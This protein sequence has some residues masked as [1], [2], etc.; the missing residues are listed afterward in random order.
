MLLPEESL[1]A[2][3]PDE[4]GEAESGPKNPPRPRAEVTERLSEKQND[5][6]VI[7]KIPGPGSKA[8]APRR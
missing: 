4:N 7:E 1:T 5:Q 8:P 6:L 2:P 3:D